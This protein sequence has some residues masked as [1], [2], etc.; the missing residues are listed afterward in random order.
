M[1][2]VSRAAR[3]GILLLA[4]AMAACSGGAPATFTLNSASVDSL[5]ACPVSAKDASYALHATID[6]RNGTSSIVTI[7]S[8][9]A[10]M[11]LTAIKGSWLQKVGDTYEAFAWN[12]SPDAVSAGRSSALKI[13]IPSACTSGRTPSVESSSGEYSVELTVITSSGTYKIASKNRHRILAG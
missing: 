6:V 10:Q 5:H 9:T 12:F 7:K 4:T 3:F 2:E 13:E 8:V 1:K 11:T